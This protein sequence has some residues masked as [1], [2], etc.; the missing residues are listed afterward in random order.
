MALWP[1]SSPAVLS[2]LEKVFSDIDTDKAM[3]ILEDARIDSVYQTLPLKDIKRRTKACGSGG[4]IDGIFWD[5]YAVHDLNAKFKNCVVTA[6]N[7]DGAR[8]Q[9]NNYLAYCK[10]EPMDYT[11]FIGEGSQFAMNNHR[12]KLMREIN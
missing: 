9:M 1:K 4:T 3:S 6:T 7:E 10:L 11:L 5:C 2:L 8:I 12:Y